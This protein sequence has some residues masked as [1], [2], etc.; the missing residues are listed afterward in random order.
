MNKILIPITWVLLS[1][2]CSSYVL[3]ALYTPGQL[4]RVTSAYSTGSYTEGTEFNYSIRLPITESWKYSPRYKLEMSG[5]IRVE[6]AATGHSVFYAWRWIDRHSPHV[7]SDIAAGS[8]TLPW[9]SGKKGDGTRIP[10]QPTEKQLK[11]GDWYRSGYPQDVF[12]QSMLKG[13]QSY[14]CIRSL[15]RRASNTTWSIENGTPSGA[16]YE[17][18]YTCPF[19]TTDDRDAFFKVTTSFFVTNEMARNDLDIVEKKLA[20]IDDLLQP[21]WDSLKVMPQAYQF[22][23]PPES[24]SQANYIIP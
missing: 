19:R 7:K 12:S 1:A 11:S 21:S 2:G 4:V 22:E 9:Y 6:G 16:G 8:R 17:V 5:L 10:Y 3:P 13:K 20:E 18:Y 15:S 14:Y 24:G 23:P